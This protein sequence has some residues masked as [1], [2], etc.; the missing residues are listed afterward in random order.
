M[1]IELNS[2]LEEYGCKNPNS[3]KETIVSECKLSVLQVRDIL[4]LLG[5]V[6]YENLDEQIY[7]A[8]IRAGYGNLNS[9]VIVVKL[10]QNTLFVAGYAKEGIIKQNI[11]E[12]A[13]QRLTDA[14]YG[15]GIIKSV[16]RKWLSVPII[17]LIIWVSIIIIGRKA[18][19]L[20]SEVIT[21]NITTDISIE[22]NSP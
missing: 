3:I 15:K 20:D 11:C 14:V 21:D 13:F 9:A 17:V 10:C 18:Y 22:N 6:L 19:T 7:V 4:L 12:Q 2:L 8:E 1:N 16:K 5:N